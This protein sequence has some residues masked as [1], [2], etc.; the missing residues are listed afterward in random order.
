[1]GHAFQKEKRFF[2]LCGRRGGLKR[3][4]SLSA[5]ERAAIA[6]TAARARWKK[7]GDT[8]S[9]LASVRLEK[10]QLGDPVFLEELITEGSLD[11]WRQIYREVADR[12]Y[13]A[14]ALALERVL[15]STDG[16]GVTPL[17]RGILK[18]I[19]GAPL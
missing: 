18:T 1:M 4:R 8:A 15:L 17:W 9:A 19:R 12:P 10:P 5:P 11:Q 14:T 6:A 3:A 13:G 7:R 16:Y 2:E